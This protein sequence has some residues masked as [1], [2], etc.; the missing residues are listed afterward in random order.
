MSNS[1]DQ[2]HQKILEDLSYLRGKFDTEIPAIKTGLQEVNNIL[3]G[4]NDRLDKI[5]RREEFNRGKIVIIA[6]IVAT[7]FTAAVN[8]VFRQF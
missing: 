4:H 8:W 7:I 2:F 6:L 5:E 1:M 3:N